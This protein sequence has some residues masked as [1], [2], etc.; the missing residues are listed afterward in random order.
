VDPNSPFGPADFTAGL[1]MVPAT[2]SNQSLFAFATALGDS[3]IGGF[4]ASP[5]RVSYTVDLDL[6]AS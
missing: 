1:S 2:S 5:F 4:V 6:T 3:G